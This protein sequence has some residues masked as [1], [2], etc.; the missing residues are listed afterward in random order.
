MEFRDLVFLD[1]IEDMDG[2]RGELREAFGLYDDGVKARIAELE[3]AVY[4]LEEKYK[5]T[6]AKNYELMLAV[7]DTPSDEPETGEDGEE[8]DI[9]SV[10][11]ENIKGD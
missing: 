4:E 11:L 10:V 2:W 1:E 7:T 9:E 8:V 6:A 5:E 3:N